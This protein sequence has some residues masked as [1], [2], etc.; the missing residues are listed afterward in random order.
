MILDLLSSYSQVE[1]FDLVSAY[2]RRLTGQDKNVQLNCARRWSGWEMAT[3]RLITDHDL[4][5]RIDSAE[6]TLQFAKIEAYVS[7]FSGD[8]GS[9][10]DLKLNRINFD[11]PLSVYWIAE[12][13]CLMQP[14]DRP[15]TITS[16]WKL[17]SGSFVRCK[18]E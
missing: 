9:C 2:H 14:V 4:L 15:I 18:N 3:S 5:K 12:A 8:I 10:W 7:Q 17:Y 6:W 1:Q 11:E 13:Y 16:T